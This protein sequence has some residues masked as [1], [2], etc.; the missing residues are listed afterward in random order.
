MGRHRNQNSSGKV[1]EVAADRVSETALT[2][3][4][5]NSGRPSS[6]TDIICYVKSDLFFFPCLNQNAI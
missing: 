3:L 1:L 4:P 6:Q 5:P 2:P